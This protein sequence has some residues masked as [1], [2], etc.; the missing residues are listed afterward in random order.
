MVSY[1]HTPQ[2]VLRHGEAEFRDKLVCLGVK[3]KYFLFI[4]RHI[5][6]KIVTNVDLCERYRLCKPCSCKCKL[7]ICRYF[8]TAFTYVVHI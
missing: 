1:I 3:D 5:A 2:D 4:Q 7:P 6:A 8:W